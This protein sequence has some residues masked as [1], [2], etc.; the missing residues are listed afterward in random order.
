MNNIYNTAQKYILIKDI[1]SLLNFDTALY[2]LEIYSVSMPKFYISTPKKK[3]CILF[4]LLFILSFIS[5][6]RQSSYL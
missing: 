3:N 2:D 5:I 1:S 4:I 6:K